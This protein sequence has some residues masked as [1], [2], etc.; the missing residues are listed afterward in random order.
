MH[1]S[2][3]PALLYL[4]CPDWPT[5]SE[6]E[7]LPAL[8][9]SKT[10]STTRTPHKAFISTPW[11]PESYRRWEEYILL[12]LINVMLTLYLVAVALV[13]KLA[14]I[15]RAILRLSWKAYIAI[16]VSLGMLPPRKLSYSD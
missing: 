15:I 10:S 4:I 6:P 3:W 11:I 16:R 1:E 2:W 12:H 9:L 7:I 8:K 13:G 14:S 5:L